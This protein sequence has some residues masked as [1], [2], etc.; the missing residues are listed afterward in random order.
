VVFVGDDVTDE[1]AF[2]VRLP[3]PAVGVRVGRSRTSAA[4]WCVA[5]RADVDR[6]L[7]HLARTLR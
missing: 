5:R 3:V 7:A 2:R 1:A 4:G 6:L